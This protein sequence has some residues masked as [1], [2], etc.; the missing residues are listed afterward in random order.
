[1]LS[2][3]CQRLQVFDLLWSANIGF[4]IQFCHLL[5]FIQVYCRLRCWVWIDFRWICVQFLD[6][7]FGEA[8]PRFV[9]CNLSDSAWFGRNF[10]GLRVVVITAIRKNCIK[11]TNFIW[12]STTGAADQILI[13][14]AIQRQFDRPPLT[15]LA[16]RRCGLAARFDGKLLE[17][18]HRL[19][20]QLA[21]L[22]HHLYKLLY[23]F[24]LVLA[25]IGRIQYYHLLR[26][27]WLLQFQRRLS[28]LCIPNILP[29]HVLP[30][31]HHGG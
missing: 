7:G 18:W 25:H 11:F 20:L 21:T 12:I 1:M 29:A 6:L 13:A 16:L 14:S 5:V 3:N 22:L 10:Q 31:H 15:L 24:H 27:L 28:R 17:N 2:E 4:S 19:A 26:L 30:A 9:F 8:K 23:V